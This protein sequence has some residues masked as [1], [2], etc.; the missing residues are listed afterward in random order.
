MPTTTRWHL[1]VVMILALSAGLFV[2]TASGQT[3]MQNQQRQNLEGGLGVTFINNETWYLFT[4]TPEFAFGNFGLGVDLNLRFNSKGQLRTADYLHFG[5]F[6]RIIRYARWAQKGDPFYIRVGA[7]DYSRIGHGFIVYN[8]RNSASY[9]YRKTGIE[10]DMDFDKGGF[11]SVYSD[12]TASSV[13]GLRGYVRP[14]RFT[15]AGKIPI[16]GGFELGATYATDLDPNSNKTFGA[17]TV[18]PVA[19]DSARTGKRMAIYGVDAGLPLLSLPVV[20]STLYTDYAQIRGYGHGTAVGIDFHFSGMGLLTI[21]AKYERRFNGDRFIP[22]YFDALYEHDRYS[23]TDTA[24]FMSRAQMLENATKSQGY[25]GELLISVLNTF[26]I[27]GGYQAPVG[28]KNQGVFHAELETPAVIPQIVVDGGFDKRNIGPVFKLDENSILY[29]EL[30]YKPIPY[31][32]VSMLYQW[33][34]A[35]Q[36][37]GTYATQRRIE[38]K[39]R[40][41]YSF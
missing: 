1:S 33:T 25:Y 9:D 18:S 23:L 7:L 36:D 20:K 10:F 32:I 41:V 4:M 13:L 28:V 17:P 37:D 31:M 3:M 21:G 27:V 16:I 34:F 2:Q 15:P 26:N 11:E 22:S 29:A 35:K 30:G 19:I 6:L 39:I 24:H 12:V 5:D 8:Y 38:P 40:F 14:L